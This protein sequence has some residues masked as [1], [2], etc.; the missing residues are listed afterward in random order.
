MKT[1]DLKIVTL[2]TIKINSTFFIQQSGTLFSI[3]P[4]AANAVQHQV[5]VW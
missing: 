5:R 2:E 3:M 4:K 1:S